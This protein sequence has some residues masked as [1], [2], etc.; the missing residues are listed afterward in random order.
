MT[1]SDIVR[2]NGEDVAQTSS[3][4]WIN[5]DI[6]I[7]LLCHKNMFSSACYSFGGCFQWMEPRLKV[8]IY[9]FIT[10]EREKNAVHKSHIRD[11][12]YKANMT[13]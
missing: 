2:D 3:L 10:S 13:T 5:F 6:E 7:C 12:D 4:L 1:D 8:F 11:G 9:L